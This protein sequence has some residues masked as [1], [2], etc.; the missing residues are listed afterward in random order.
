MQLGLNLANPVV[1]CWI[2]LQKNLV[3]C[4]GA[5]STELKTCKNWRTNKQWKK[6]FKE[7]VQIVSLRYA[8]AEQR[9]SWNFW[10]RWPWYFETEFQYALLSLFFL[11][12][13]LKKCFPIY[14]QLLDYRLKWIGK[15]MGLIMGEILGEIFS[16]ESRYLAHLADLVFQTTKLCCDR[17]NWASQTWAKAK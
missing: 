2:D 13:S 5:W 3:D 10:F 8:W 14:S 1:V 7:V 16:L 4:K 15:I 17:S 9:W 12:L 6:Q 11:Y